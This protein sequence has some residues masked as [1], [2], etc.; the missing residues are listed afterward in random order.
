MSKQ[1]GGA[2][3]TAAS[4]LFCEYRAYAAEFGDALGLSHGKFVVMSDG[5]A[6]AGDFES[7]KELHTVRREGEALHD[8]DVLSIERLQRLVHEGLVI[9]V[10][11]RIPAV[12]CAL[13][14]RPTAAAD[15]PTDG[16]WLLRLTKPP[17]HLFAVLL[18]ALAYALHLLLN[19]GRSRWRRIDVEIK[20]GAN[21]L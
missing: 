19:V 13:V 10:R 21:A 6:G 15:E 11:E 9:P 5:V 20:H 7:A 16:S 1:Y 14:F 3:A 2:A 12:G 17:F 8:F 4:L 18:A